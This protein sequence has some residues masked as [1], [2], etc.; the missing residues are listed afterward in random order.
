MHYYVN[1]NNN[2]ARQLLTTKDN[3]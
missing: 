2:L 1:K 3:L